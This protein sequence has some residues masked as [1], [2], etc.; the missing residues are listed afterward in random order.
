MSPKIALLFLVT[1]DIVNIDIWKNWMKGHEDY[2]SVYSH[3]SLKSDDNVK[4]K[5]LTDSR[6]FPVFTKWGDISL[7]QAEREL[8]KNAL[9]DKRNKYF[10]LLS[11][12]CIPLHTFEHT[13]DYI[14]SDPRGILDYSDFHKMSKDDNPVP[15]H[16][17]IECNDL[18]KKYHFHK[19]MS[20]SSHQ[21]KV[22]NVQNAKDFVA[23]FQDSDYVKLFTN[24]CIEVVPESLA[25]DELMYINWLKFKY[26]DKF[27]KQ[28]R[29]GAV[30]QADF[31]GK[32]IHP[33]PR[34]EII[35]SV[36]RYG[37]SEDGPLFARKYPNPSVK[38]KTQVPLD[39]GF[40]S[41]RR[42]K[43]KS[44]TKQSRRKKAKRSKKHRKR[45]SRVSSRYSR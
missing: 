29:Q 30:T 18:L 35:P 24:Y 32:A 25:P 13:Y 44:K 26:G 1:K 7:M 10:I 45:A 38:L 14:F 42:S 33:I 17:N 23:M 5:L 37:C 19:G 43:K 6:V 8:L 16:Y 40:E 22:L 27:K 15:F 34:T 9:Q 39:C 36:K 31:K 11:D 3:Y 20:Y 21:W 2:F 41:S 4:Q 28:I 12:T